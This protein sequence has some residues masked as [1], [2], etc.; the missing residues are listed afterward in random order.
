MAGQYD[1][2]RFTGTQ[3]ADAIRQQH[4]TESAARAVAAKSRQVAPGTNPL[5]RP[6]AWAGE[7]EPRG[8]AGM[9]VVAGRRPDG[10]SFGGGSP[11]LDPYS[12]GPARTVG[13]IS[14]PPPMTNFL[15]GDAMRNS[16]AEHRTVYAKPVPMPTLDAFGNKSNVPSAADNLAYYRNPFENAQDHQ[17]RLQDA[18]QS[19][20]TNLQTAASQKG[21]AMT[22]FGNVQLA[23]AKPSAPSQNFGGYDT[24]ENAVAA[25]NAT[26]AAHPNVG[27]AGTP[28]NKAFVDHYNQFGEKSAH[29]N[30]SSLFKSPVAAQ[31]PISQPAQTVPPVIAAAQ[32]PTHAFLDEGEPKPAPI[33][34]PGSP[35]ARVG[36]FAMDAY[37]SANNAA[38]GVLT[39]AG[40]NPDLA[41]QLGP[42]AR[43]TATS[44]IPF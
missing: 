10:S 25:R 21:G 6:P 16:M 2:S 42:L 41:K 15:P 30:L 18:Q 3:A 20:A 11:S 37:N 44:L 5:S 35:L 39:K 12:T 8:L 17:Q 38:S 32:K 29:D 13:S 26:L 24:L 36:N 22:P 34:T 14:N 31:S 28:E 33:I 7:L 43:R 40:I 19:A 9:G 4:A 23:Q 1:P 27:I